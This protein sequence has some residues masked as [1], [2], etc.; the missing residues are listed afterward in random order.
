MNPFLNP[1]TLA[2]VAKYYL[3]DVNRIWTYDWEKL[4]EYR[5][6]QFRRILKLAMKT[7]MYREKYKGIDVSK[8]TLQNIDE[9]P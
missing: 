9:L 6:K 8:I 5:E 2:R 1:V 3:T 7:P 4:E